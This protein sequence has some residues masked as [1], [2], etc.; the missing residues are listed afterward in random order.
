MLLG[1]GALYDRLS[2]YLD[3]E[4]DGAVRFLLDV[5]FWSSMVFGV[6]NSITRPRDMAAATDREWYRSLKRSGRRFFDLPGWA[7]LAWHPLR[8]MQTLAA[9][10]VWRGT[11]QDVFSDPMQALLLYLTLID[12]WRTAFY[13]WHAIGWSAGLM[14]AVMAASVNVTVQMLLE[15]SV[16]G[17]LFLPSVILGALVGAHNIALY[18][19][20]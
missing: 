2:E 7:F 3:I 20:N 13:D 18:A 15:D 9:V 6:R 16:A 14:V 4:A 1:L 17:W 12:V 5:A 10:R 8:A 11:D 19:D